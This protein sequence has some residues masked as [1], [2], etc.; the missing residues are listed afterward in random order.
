LVAFPIAAA[1][2]V[3]AFNFIRFPQACSLN[4]LHMDLATSHAAAV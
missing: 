4:L 3:V 1:C 2:T